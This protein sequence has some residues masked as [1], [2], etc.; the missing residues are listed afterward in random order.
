MTRNIDVKFRVR[1]SS[2]RNV[3]ERIVHLQNA[4]CIAHAELRI[5]WTATG[6]GD[7]AMPRLLYSYIYEMRDVM[8]ERVDLNE[9]IENEVD[10]YLADIAALIRDTVEFTAD[11][12]E[13]AATGTRGGVFAESTGHKH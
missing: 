8:V 6:L 3:I 10:V 13:F 2:R 5:A 11:V 9:Y 1:Q 4:L 7:E 12:R